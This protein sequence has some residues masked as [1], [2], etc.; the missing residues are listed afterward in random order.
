M[1][2]RVFRFARSG[3]AE[4]GEYFDRLAFGD[5]LIF[6]RVRVGVAERHAAIDDFVVR[7][8]EMGADRLVVI[9]EESLRA[10]IEAAR[11]AVIRLPRNMPQSTSM[12]LPRRLSSVKIRP[13]G[14]SKKM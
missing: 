7:N 12:P 4:I 13:T 2:L 8:A 14:A 6:R 1:P 9:G 11:A 10:G 5:Q 3:D